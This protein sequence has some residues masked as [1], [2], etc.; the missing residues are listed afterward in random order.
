MIHLQASVKTLNTCRLKAS[1]L[2]SQA[3]SNQFMHHW[4]VSVCGSSLV[5]KNMVLYVNEPSLLTIIVKGKT[6]KTTYNNFV[7]QLQHI[8]QRF[9]FPDAFIANEINLANEYV[10]GKT[11]NKTMVAHIN[12]I[13]YNVTYWCSCY[14]NYDAINCCIM[15]DRQMD[16]LFKNKND[17]DYTYTITYWE[18]Q[19]NF[20][21]KKN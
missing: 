3:A 21:A 9:H 20:I 16:Y 7:L 2:V 8:L 17:K 4:Y 12:N 1:M 19:L 18:K 5:G 6:I 10:V 15:E 14:K 13:M 11:T